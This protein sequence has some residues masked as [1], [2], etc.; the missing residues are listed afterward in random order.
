V[1]TP[2]VFALFAPAACLA[3]IA[4]AAERT[5]PPCAAPQT[6][7]SERGPIAAKP[8]PKLAPT[9]EPV[10]ALDLVNGRYV[11]RAGERELELDPSDG[12]RVTAFRLGGKNILIEA[13]ASPDGYG[14]SFWPS[15]QSA[16]G[17]PPPPELATNAWSASVKATTL[18]LVSQTN[19][20]LSIHAEQ[21]VHFD[22]KLGAAEFEYRIVN[23]GTKPTRVAPWQNTRVHPGGLT[24]FP[25]SHGPASERTSSAPVST[26]ALDG[27]GEF[28]WLQHDP[29]RFTAGVKA[30][31]DG[32]EGW[33]AHA[34]HGQLFV[35]SFADV[36]A[37]N[38][39][40]G[41]AEIEIYVDGKGVFVEVENQGPYREIAAGE[42]STWNVR[43]R[44]APIPPDVPIEVGS[45]KLA[46]LA[47]ELAASVA[48]P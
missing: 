6:L 48:P 3:L 39:A 11:F 45:A 47:R 24:F 36:P 27:A 2:R 19:P 13:G 43:W 46:H 26:L 34:A 18:A 30:F 1:T 29:A 17:W 12:G 25:S 8:T 38:Q 21:S 14:S 7:P 41:E 44:I 22:A 40:P 16:W 35:K 28:T 37:A 4:C 32:A 42:T 15:P 9:P 23:D 10:A 5:A 31:A 20:L 33:I